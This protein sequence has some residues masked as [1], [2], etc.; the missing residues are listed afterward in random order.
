MILIE[1]KQ[2]VFS[3]PEVHPS[4]AMRVAFQRTRRSRDDRKGDVLPNA[5]DRCPLYH[6][7]DFAGKISAAWLEHGGVMLPMAQSEALRL[8]FNSAYIEDS[9]SAYP[10]AVLV[11]AGKINAVTGQRWENTLSR[12][13]QNYL[14]IPEQRKLD[15]YCSG[16]G[17]VRQ[18]VA[19]PMGSGQTV[20]EQI[21][22]QSVY[23]GLQIMVF[24]MK[25]AAFIRRFPIR[26]KTRYNM[27]GEPSPAYGMGLAPGRRKKQKHAQDPY[28]LTDWDTTHTSRC[29]VHIADAGEWEKSS[30][31]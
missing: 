25:S 24:P 8:T 14:V 15:G 22:G 28:D 16:P 20:E 11:A 21:T 1:N 9:G 12:H 3:F 26:N 19:A 17:I 31:N 10:F 13:P 2:L 30:G 18:F 27:V 29:F 7:D 5:T 6:V 4:A 23:G